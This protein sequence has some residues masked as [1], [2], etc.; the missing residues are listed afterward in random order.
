MSTQLEKAKAELDATKAELKTARDE[1]E[2]GGARYGARG[3]QDSV[4]EAA[5]T[6]EG[7]REQEAQAAAEER[8]AAAEERAAAA[9]ERAAAAE[10]ALADERA[11]REAAEAALVE[12]QM[13]REAAE[14]ALVEA[15]AAAIKLEAAETAL[16]EAG[17]R[18]REQAPSSSSGAVAGAR[19]GA[20]APEPVPVADENSGESMSGRHG[21]HS[22]GGRGLDDVTKLG[23]VT[24][25]ADITLAVGGGSP[26]KTSRFS[27]RKEKAVPATAPAVEAW[28]TV[29][30]AETEAD[31][32]EKG[33]QLVKP[34]KIKKGLQAVASGS[35]FRS[36]PKEAVSLAADVCQGE[37]VNDAFAAW[38]LTKTSS[39][40]AEPTPVARR[41]RG[42]T[43]ATGH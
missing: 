11:A 19:R 38:G 3:A 26:Q 39:F 27:Y 42:A 22:S 21:R 1:L 8:A 4:E 13:A 9:E 23:D 34:S 28:V 33:L 17:K 36:K 18:T 24:N 43:R 5:H 6:G 35:I 31:S 25:A 7:E 41:T 40:T 30:T 15:K 32:V 14:A 16:Y 10:K 2:G 12:E 37:T 29:A 20:A